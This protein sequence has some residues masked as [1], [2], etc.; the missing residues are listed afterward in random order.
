MSRRGRDDGLKVR[1]RTAKGRSASSSRWLR[2]QLSDPYVAKA[3]RMGLRSRAAFKLMEIDDKFGFLKPG[4]AIV[5]LGA[6]P[7]GWAQVAAQRVGADAGKGRVVAI[8]LLPMDPIPGVDIL[9][10][11]F[12]SEEAPGRLKGL[13][14]GKADA[15]LSDMAPNTTGH[16]RT[17]HLRIVALAEAALDF[18][19]EVLAPGGTFVAKVWAGGS[20]AELLAR[21][22]RDFSQVRHVKPK[23]SRSESPEVYVVATG[24]RG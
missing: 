7:G 15:V 9:E 13:L 10:L 4:A 20:E 19:R 8:D 11:D 17:D 14:G 2:R 1:L 6:A 23:A 22:K 16:K 21:M 24:F 5:D 12:Y 3:R 18:A